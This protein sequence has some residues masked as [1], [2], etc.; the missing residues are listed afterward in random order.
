M[1]LVGVL[2]AHMQSVP[3]DQ[4]ETS[5]GVL[6]GHTVELSPT[7][8]RSTDVV[9]S[10]DAGEADARV[11]EDL[12]EPGGG[13]PLAPRGPVSPAGAAESTTIQKIPNP[14]NSEM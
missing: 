11:T 2:T 3:R 12:G 1:F 6:E 9:A 14:M 10:F 7:A 8:R 4:R 5:I 13:L